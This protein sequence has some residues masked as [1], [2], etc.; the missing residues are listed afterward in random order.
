MS[1]PPHQLPPGFLS[2][3]DPIEEN[4]FPSDDPRHQIWSDA[5]REAEEAIHRFNSRLLQHTAEVTALGR[6]A[7]GHIATT[8]R[9]VALL[10]NLHNAWMQDLV[11]GKFDIWAN[12]N[13]AVVRTRKAIPAFDRWLFEYAQAWLDT[14][15]GDALRSEA[16]SGFN[17]RVDDLLV[18]L[19]V[20][21]TQ[22]LEH[23]RAEAR[24][25]VS[26]WEAYIASVQRAAD[27]PP[28]VAAEPMP[29]LVQPPPAA[30]AYPD[31]SGP[32]DV[33]PAAMAVQ[34]AST[35]ADGGDSDDRRAAVEAFLRRGSHEPDLPV[36]LTKTHIWRAARHTTSRQ[37]EHWQANDGKATGADDQN[38]GR[39]I[40]MP[41]TAFVA[42]LRGMGLLKEPGS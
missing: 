37:F 30:R 14:I 6:N 19:K 1:F 23:W 20:R 31:V 9:A 10:P 32:I 4:P 12:R 21:L 13:L 35:T 40:A 3:G 24:K 15:R 33:V 22:R 39:I 38:F 18:D 26:E 16:E 28:T 27:Q 5:T 25:W 11:A 36:R 17:L 41:P 42:L 2:S 29:K 34:P 8:E 7:F